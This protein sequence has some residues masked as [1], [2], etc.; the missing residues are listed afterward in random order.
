MVE[1]SR[2]EHDKVDW[3]PRLSEEHRRQIREI[4]GDKEEVTPMKL[5]RRM[6]TP[7]TEG[8]PR[9]LKAQVEEVMSTLTTRERR[10]LELRF[11]LEDGRSRTQ[12]EAG[13]EIGRSRWTVGR[14]E[15]RAIRKL[16]HPSTV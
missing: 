7:V 6:V 11:G 1:G 3:F 8:D 16:R 15:R 14:I 12:I 4:F 5:L 2:G 9:S 13:K 10:V